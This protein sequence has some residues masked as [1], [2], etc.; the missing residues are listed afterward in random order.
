MGAL[1]R[2]ALVATGIAVLA[3]AAGLDFERMRTHLYVIDALYSIAVFL[4][5][6]ALVDWV[7]SLW[8]KLETNRPKL[9]LTTQLANAFAVVHL[10]GDKAQHVQI[11][12]I[13]SAKGKPLWIRFDSIDFLGGNRPEAYPPFRL[14]IGGNLRGEG[15][16]GK[17]KFV[18]F[19]GD[20]WGRET[21][22]YPVSIS[23]R[24]NGRQMTERQ[25][26]TFHAQ[27]GNLTVSGFH[28]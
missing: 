2:G 7:I 18:F 19:R 4:L 6:V 26:L 1:P 24:W 9:A 21:V 3:I 17:A 16:M 14:D 5:A 8:R 10:A 23:F 13:Q 28:G 15:D 25:K 20:S 22:E 27:T 11:E 12:P